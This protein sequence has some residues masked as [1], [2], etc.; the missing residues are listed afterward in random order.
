M[1]KQ[2]ETF[3]DRP[4]YSLSELTGSIKAVINKTYTRLANSS[5]ISVNSQAVSFE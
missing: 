3:N 2:R 4:V 1:E 5:N